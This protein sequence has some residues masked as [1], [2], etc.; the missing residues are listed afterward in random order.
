MLLKNGCNAHLCN[1]Q[2][3]TELDT[4]CSD[5]S[6]YVDVPENHLRKTIC[7]HLLLILR[8]LNNVLDLL[9]IF[10]KSQL[11]SGQ[12]VPYALVLRVISA[13]IQYT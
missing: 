2:E 13:C 8:R 6:A 12:N 4:Q 5:L 10:H 1:L 3:Y 11:L 7:F 9:I